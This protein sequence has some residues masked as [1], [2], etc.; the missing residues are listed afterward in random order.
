VSVLDTITSYL[1]GKGLTP[2]QIAGVEGNLKIESGLNPAAS[3][4]RE[5]AIGLAQWEKGRRTR[6]QQFAAAHGGSE[7]DLYTQLDFMWSELTGP[8]SGALSAL[9]AT[10]TPAQAATVWDQ[11][12]ERS[13]GTSR[14]A[15][16]DA[17]NAYY[18]G[19]GGDPSGG[20]SSGSTS[21]S[22]GAPAWTAI[23][24]GGGLSLAYSGL[25]SQWANDAMSIGLKVLGVGTAVALVVVGAV[26]TVTDK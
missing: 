14:Q 12:Y 13:A 21:G 5:G 16:I 18:S 11:K 23:V 25:K 8:E 9:L 7:T 22:G 6:L 19:T 20:T 4:P 24:P 1:R 15:R 2:A 26:H 3:N 17:A 10:T